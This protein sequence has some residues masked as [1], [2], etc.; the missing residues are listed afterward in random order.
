MNVKKQQNEMWRIAPKFDW[1]N[2]RENYMNGNSIS[3]W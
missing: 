1:K 2:L 3:C